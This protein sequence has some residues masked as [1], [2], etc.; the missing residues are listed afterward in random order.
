MERPRRIVSLAPSA[1]E[2]LFALGL[3]EEIVGISDADDFPPGR[4][5]GRTR[6]GGVVIGVE[7]V[8][9]LRPDLVIGILGIQREQIERL[10]SV[11]LPVLA[12]DA[13]TFD[14]TLALIR[15]VG[16]ATGRL[17]EAEALAA[18]LARQAAAVRPLG[19]RTVYIEVWREPVM[20]AGG[21]TLVHDLVARAGGVN[22]FAEL[23]GYIQVQ[24][25]GVIAR[26][27]EVVF[28]L[29][30]GANQVKERA[31]WGSVPAV[32]SGRVYE[33]PTSL[34]SRPGPR[35][36]EGLSLV[37]RLLQGPR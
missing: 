10:R 12:L 29:Y 27:P 8:I 35:V 37:A 36:G 2:V 1:T 18:S 21:Q 11:G 20:A 33:L 30:P 19:A 14:E 34:V 28:L 15:E 22:V 16:R 9:A 5:E 26:A 13:G 32:R 31:G 7:R 23:R 25:E 6:V 17:A 3:D 24:S 4:L